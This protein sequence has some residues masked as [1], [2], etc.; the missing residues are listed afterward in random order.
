MRQHDN[1][2]ALPFHVAC[3]TAAPVEIL[4]LLLQEYPGALH[5]TNNNGSFPSHCAC[6]ANAPSLAV[7]QFLVER[8]PAA[9]RALDNTGALPLHRLCGSNPLDN[10]LALLLDAYEGTIFVRT[11]TGV[12]PFIVACQTRA[13][14]SVML[15]LLRAY[16][17]TLEDMM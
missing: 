4:S 17:D 8:E 7:P 12:S 11:Y 15:I 16:P 13:P 1:T 14:L 9:V 6:Q 5:V 3:R 2:G 10:A